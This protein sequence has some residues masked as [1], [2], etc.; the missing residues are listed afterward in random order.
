MISGRCDI[1][2]IKKITIRI[3]NEIRSA[4]NCTTNKKYPNPTLLGLLGVL[5]YEV[6]F[7][8]LKPIFSK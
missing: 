1:K 3:G 6:F 7:K 2:N 5:A 8:N 4:L